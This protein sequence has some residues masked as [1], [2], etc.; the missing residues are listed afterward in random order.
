MKSMHSYTVSF[1]VAALL[2]ASATALSAADLEFY[3][4]V[5]VNAPAVETI[6]ALTDEWAAKNP[7]HSVK[8]VYAGNYEETT[9]KALTAANYKFERR[10]RDM[11]QDI[12]SGGKR[13]DEMDLATL[14]QFW[15]A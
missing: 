11:E 8:A 14:D 7:Q 15:R 4:P 10:F 9:T 2:G 3:F 6:Q 5:G 12:T 13:V 1:G